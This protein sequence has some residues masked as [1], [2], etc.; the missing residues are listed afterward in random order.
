M[1]RLIIKNKDISFNYRMNLLS[2]LIIC[3][4]LII[5][6]SPISSAAEFDSDIGSSEWTFMIFLNGDNN[7]EEYAINDFIEMAKAGST[8]EVNII[9][10]MDRRSGYDS[11]YGDWTGT[12]RFRVIKDMT[13]ISDNAV[14]DIGEANMGDPQTIIDFVHW[15]KTN[16]QADHY[17]L[18]I[19][20]HGSG[21]KREDYEPPVKSI[22]SDDT[23]NDE[24]TMQELRQALAAITNDGADKLDII[25]FD[26]CL[27]GMEEVDYQIMPYAS[28]R[29]SSEELE[30]SNGWDYT[31]SMT[32]LINNPKCTSQQL[33]AQI[34]SDYITYTGTSG[35]HTL[36]AVDLNNLN[37]LATATSKLGNDL[38]NALPLYRT[39]IE[40]VNDRV[41]CFPYYD[42]GFYSYIDLHDYARL[43]SE[44]INDPVIIN[45][46]QNVMDAITNTVIAEAHGSIHSNSRGISIYLPDPRYSTYLTNYETDL[47]FSSDTQ[48]DEFLCMFSDRTPPTRV[49]DLHSTS[50]SIN[51]WSMDCT[52]DINW[53]AAQDATSG[54]NGYSTQWS[55]FSDTLPDKIK[56]IEYNITNITSHSLSTANDWYFHIRSVDNAGNWNGTATHI[57]PFYI[58]ETLVYDICGDVDNDR[59]VD[60]DDVYM[61]LGHV[62][63]GTAINE[64]VGDVDGSGSINILDVRLLMNHVADRVYELNC[65]FKRI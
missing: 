63:T 14:Q 28:Y 11:S 20:D 27:M 24:I 29:V 23:D 43:I 32:Y 37:D 15:T 22:S 12:K 36:S 30:P 10:Q 13:P 50:H 57:G 61:L 52:I 5:S 45:D 19:W 64:Q 26:A 48:W 33:S 40:E 62:F 46:A 1:K 25:G 44:S 3:L 4:Y 35:Y 54:L 18:V 41:E 53:T 58:N 17:A 51:T 9:V 65:T 55:H 16:Y 42:H 8:D 59:D 49:I 2:L 60:T 56:D 38:M 47:V 34:V 31:A 6:I 39:Q 7:L 21:W